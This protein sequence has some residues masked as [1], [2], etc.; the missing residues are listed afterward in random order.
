MPLLT[1]VTLETPP[2]LI[3]PVGVVR[4][5]K[6][7]LVFSEFSYDTYLFA[8]VRT[9]Y[10]V[11]EF[12]M[13]PLEV[14]NNFTLVLPIIPPD[15]AVNFMIAV[16]IPNGTAWPTRRKLYATVG[17]NLVY[18]QYNGEVITPDSVFEIW[19]A[20]DSPTTLTVPFSLLTS[21]TTSTETDCCCVSENQDNEDALDED[22]AIWTDDLA[23][24]IVFDTCY[25]GV[26]PSAPSVPAPTLLVAEFSGTPLTGS[27]PL[28]V[29]FT[30]LSTGSPTGWNW[31]F[32]FAG[33]GNT[34]IL[35]NPVVTF[36]TTGTYTI[37]LTVNDGVGNDTETKVGYI[38]VIV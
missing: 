38:T 20:D 2:Q 7:S 14:L 29:T 15:P 30:D 35:Q 9:S 21:L 36:P 24:P 6:N 32:G 13:D 3:T 33:V 27:D 8:D 22:C 12:V 25:G 37:M 4:R 10:I 16:R 18:P 1:P 28:S 23:L 11:T 31:Y 17:E 34:S 26:G 19:T 5:I